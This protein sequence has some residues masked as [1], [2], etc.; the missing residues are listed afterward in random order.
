M[1]SRSGPRT[2]GTLR[3]RLSSNVHRIVPLRSGLG[4]YSHGRWRSV[5]RHCASLTLQGRS[6]SP[7]RPHI[8]TPLPLSRS[9]RASPPVFPPLH[10]LT[11]ASRLGLGPLLNARRN[12]VK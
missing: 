11:T 12:V 9:K 4:V 1:L 5:Q 7:T 3:R 6:L 2:T 10:I 8:C